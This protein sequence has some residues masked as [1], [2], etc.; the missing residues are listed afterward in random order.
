MFD[1]S[2]AGLADLIVA[3]AIASKYGAIFLPEILGA[4]RIHEG[5]LGSRTLSKT[6]TLEA[7]LGSV[8]ARG[9]AMNPHLFT[10]A[11]IDRH[12][13]CVCFSAIRRT[14]DLAMA[15]T[16]LKDYGIGKRFL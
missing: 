14:G 10:G 9:A 3:L 15:R 13:R 4:I 8:S 11:F 2:C 6:V 5:G 7:V 1:S 16:A 12:A